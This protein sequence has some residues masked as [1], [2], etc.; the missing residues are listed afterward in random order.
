MAAQTDKEIHKGCLKY[1][2]GLVRIFALTPI[3]G[4][5]WYR[6][7]QLTEATSGDYAV[8]FVYIGLY[9]AFAVLEAI[10]SVA[11]EVK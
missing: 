4:Y 2:S 10:V 5:L 7:F 11:T 1:G 9:C 3:W 8:L 6:L